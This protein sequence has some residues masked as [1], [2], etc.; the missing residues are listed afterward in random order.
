MIPK[1]VTGAT[2][3]WARIVGFLLVLF[4]SA[5]FLFLIFSCVVLG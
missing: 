2:F 5:C 4:L 3:S 1:V